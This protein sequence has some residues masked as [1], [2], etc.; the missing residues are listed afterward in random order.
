[1]S[2]P[3]YCP[4]PYDCEADSRRRARMGFRSKIILCT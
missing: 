4:G 1:M 2:N 3:G